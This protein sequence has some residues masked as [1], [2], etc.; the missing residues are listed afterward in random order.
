MLLRM[1][2]SSLASDRRDRHAVLVWL[3]A[4]ALVATIAWV[5]HRTSRSLAAE[6]RAVADASFEL[7]HAPVTPPPALVLVSQRVSRAGP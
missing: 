1:D 6:L 2:T 4:V 5:A 3:L 7:Q